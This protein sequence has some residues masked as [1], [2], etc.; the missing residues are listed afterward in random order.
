MEFYG[1][2]NVNSLIYDSNHLLPEQYSPASKPLLFPIRRKWGFRFYLENVYS[3]IKSHIYT[4]I[5]FDD[6]PG[7][8]LPSGAYKSYTEHEHWQLKNYV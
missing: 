5:I 8:C 3:F 4:H 2:V 1:A 6:C 7:I